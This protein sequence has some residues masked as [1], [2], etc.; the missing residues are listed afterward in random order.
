LETRLTHLQKLQISTDL[1][2]TTV[3]F[4]IEITTATRLTAEIATSGLQLKEI[5]KLP[6]LISDLSLSAK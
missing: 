2:I 3:S 1:A 4:T 5:K 6:D